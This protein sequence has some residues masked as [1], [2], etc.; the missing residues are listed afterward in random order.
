V[1][2]KQNQNE[3]QKNLPINKIEDV[4]FSMDQA[5]QDDMK[6]LERSE[7]AERRQESE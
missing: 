5:D 2:N 6:A 1:E 4:E 7:Q 3:M